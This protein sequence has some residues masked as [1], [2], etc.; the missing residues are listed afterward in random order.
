MTLHTHITAESDVLAALLGECQRVIEGIIEADHFEHDE[1]RHLMR[2]LQGRIT[3]ARIKRLHLSKLGGEVYGQFMISIDGSR[4]PS[5]VHT[6][7]SQAKA[8]AKRLAN[9]EGQNA[10]TIR[11]L[12]VVDVLQARQVYEWAS[13][14][15]E[16]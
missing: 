2:A 12:E 15:G 4:A 9:Q 16:A 5:K 11:I 10:R 13:A 7:L 3:E 8:E 14:G 1:E 6:H